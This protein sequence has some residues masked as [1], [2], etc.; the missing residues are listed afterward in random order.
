MRKTL[1]EI[2]EVLIKHK[3]N[4]KEKFSVLRIGVFGSFAKGKETEKSD[5]DIYIEFD[6]EKITFA[7]YLELIDYLEGIFGRKVDIITRDSVE[8][9]R[10]PHIKEEI[11][12]EIIY[13]EN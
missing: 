6:I 7:K 3:H 2:I 8:T 1:D 9:I 12:R 11:K 13:A 4:L 5:I 10:I